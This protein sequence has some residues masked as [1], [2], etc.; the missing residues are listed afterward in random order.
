MPV[1]NLAAPPWCAG[2]KRERKG[3]PCVVGVVGVGYGS[4]LGF[5]EEGALLTIHAERGD[6]GKL[7]VRPTL[8]AHQSLGHLERLAQGADEAPVLAARVVPGAFTDGNL[9]THH[10]RKEEFADLLI[11]RQS[12][13]VRALR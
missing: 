9:G 6:L 11:S 2:E 7:N 4:L 1:V 10:G 5:V 8:R 3:V 12:L 13:A